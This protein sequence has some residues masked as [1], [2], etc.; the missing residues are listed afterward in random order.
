VLAHWSNARWLLFNLA[1]TVN[2]AEVVVSISMIQVDSG[3]I[4]ATWGVEINVA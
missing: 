1:E 4:A 3:D 2:I